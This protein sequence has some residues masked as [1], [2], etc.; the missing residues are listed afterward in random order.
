MRKSAKILRVFADK[1]SVSGFAACRESVWDVLKNRRR[2]RDGS[3]RT[4]AGTQGIRTA[5]RE[6]Y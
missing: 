2:I 5:E 4:G 6:L 1:L 3:R